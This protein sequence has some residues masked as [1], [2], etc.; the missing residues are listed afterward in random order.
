MRALIVGCAVALAV[1]T[2]AGCA[3]ESGI[4][5]PVPSAAV[6]PPV[7][8]PVRLDGWK[9][10]LPVPGKGGAA[11]VEPA[12]PR[13]PWL[14]VDGQGGLTLW[15]PVTGSTTAHSTHARTELDSLTPFTA[16]TGRHVLAAVVAVTQFPR[17]TPDVIVGQL[18]GADALS[19]IPFV[20]LHDDGGAIGVVVKHDRS[21]PDADRV[22]L[23][24]HVPLGARFG[25][26][27]SDNG[28]GT[29]TFTASTDGRTV[30]ASAAMPAAFRGVDVRFQAG[31]YQ[32]A[33][34]S[35]GGGAADD[36]ARVSLHALRVDP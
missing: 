23:L 18:H 15:A 25:F 26:T 3:A 27:I 10:T 30:T 8:G 21:G 28:D 1:G 14:V 12:A 5:H 4:P 29:L 6:T 17:A 24:A 16:A 9:L 36:G 11:I 13:A 2:A 32:Q 19:S 20:M 33:D 22:P 34:S 31:A 7:T 35:S